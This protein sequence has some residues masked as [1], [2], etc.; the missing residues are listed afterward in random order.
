MYIASAADSAKF[1]KRFM[2]MWK[3]ADIYINIV[4]HAMQIISQQFTEKWRTQGYNSHQRYL[5]ESQRAK[6]IVPGAAR[7]PF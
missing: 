3:T 6:G 4:L 7:R 2:N 5:P 1:Q